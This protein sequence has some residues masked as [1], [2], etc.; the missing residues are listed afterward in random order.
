MARADEH[1]W[2]FKGSQLQFQLA[3]NRYCAELN[4]ALKASVDELRAARIHWRAPLEP[5]KLAEPRDDRFLQAAGLDW[6]RADL[7][8]FWPRGGPVWDG[9]AQVSLADGTSGVFLVEAKSYPGE[10]ESTCRA[11]PPSRDLI[12]QRLAETRRTL[13]VDETFAEA[14]LLRYYQLANRLA[15]LVWLREKGVCAW[16]V[17]AGFTDDVGHVPTASAEWAAGYE[18][19]AEVMGIDLSRV[20]G[21]VHLEL[22]ARARPGLSTA[23]K[24]YLAT[25]VGVESR[26]GWAVAGVV[27]DELGSTL[28]VLTAW[29]PG[30]ARPSVAENRVANERLRAELVRRG[31]TVFHAVGTSST[32][33]HSEESYA[34]PDLSRSAACELGRVFG[35]AAI[36]EISAET[37]TVVSSDESWEYSR[38]V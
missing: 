2:A 20:E 35:Q 34:I 10:L 13:E 31:L 11:E 23:Q 24:A 38:P 37:Q 8:A 29:N 18:S 1:G 7:K 30:D 25:E 33:D 16:L 12:E 32:G 3:V 28:H 21:L 6:M 22:E 4:D 19:V 9:V 17:L 14:W 36:F 26:D 5:E 15:H 27:A